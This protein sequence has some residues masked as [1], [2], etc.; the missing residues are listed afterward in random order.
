MVKI[1]IFVCVKKTNY[2]T[3]NDLIYGIGDLFE[4]TFEI[5]AAAGNMPN[6]LISLVGAGALFYCGKIAVSEKNIVE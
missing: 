3:M 6:L 2:I 5:L 1:C 4:A